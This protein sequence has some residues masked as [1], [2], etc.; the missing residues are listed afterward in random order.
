[1]PL[2]RSL[3]PLIQSSRASRSGMLGMH[4]WKLCWAT[5]PRKS[6]VL[7]GCNTDKPL[8]HCYP[9]VQKHA[10]TRPSHCRELFELPFAACTSNTNCECPP[11]CWHTSCGGL[12]LPLMLAP[13]S[14]LQASP[15][16]CSSETR[17]VCS[18]G[19]TQWCSQGPSTGSWAS[20]LA[21][22]M[23]FWSPMALRQLWLGASTMAAPCSESGQSQPDTVHHSVSVYSMSCW[24]S[25][26]LRP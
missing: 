7:M 12:S 26:L 23:Q 18:R 16:W 17:P 4:Q 24:R 13:T 9:G 10:Q 2:P 15:R 1:M 3:P 21:G 22:A 25:G 14:A 8:S 20:S 11:P 19:V 6:E 5:W